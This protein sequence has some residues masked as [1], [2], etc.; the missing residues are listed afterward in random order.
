[1]SDEGMSKDTL[2]ERLGQLDVCLISDVLDRLGLPGAVAGILP[3]WTGARMFGEVV[4]MSLGPAEGQ[5]APR[6]LGVAALE[7]AQPTNVIVIEH[8]DDPPIVASSWGGLLARAALARQVSGIVI[9]GLC[10]DV[11]EIRELGLPVSA[12]GVVPFTAR[13]RVIEVAMG[14]PV[15]IAGVSVSPGDLVLGDGTGVVFIAAATAEE[16]VR[17]GEE[18]GA[19]EQLMAQDIEK[20]VLPSEVLSGNYEAMLDRS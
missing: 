14:E 12:R 2:V 11:D 8:R 15:T 19:R 13:R 3:I 7:Q 5:R 9:D 4:T 10:R 1:M 16:V 20:G 18:L 17:V 6:H